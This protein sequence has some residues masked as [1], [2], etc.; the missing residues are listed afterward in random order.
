MIIVGVPAEQADAQEHLTAHA[1]LKALALPPFIEF[2]AID[3]ALKHSQ[4]AGTEIDAKKDD[5][6]L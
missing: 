2:I 3:F 4:H 5:A 1:N 6:A